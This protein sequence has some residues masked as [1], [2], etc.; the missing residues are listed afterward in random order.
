MKS[1]NITIDIN[2][3]YSS[4]YTAQLLSFGPS[5]DPDR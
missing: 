3:D 1:E 5:F 4:E 2:I